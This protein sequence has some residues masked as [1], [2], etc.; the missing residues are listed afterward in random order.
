MPTGPGVQRDASVLEDLH[1]IDDEPGRLIEAIKEVMVFLQDVGVSASLSV[2]TYNEVRR[3]VCLRGAR[4]EGVIRES[5]PTA[6][7]RAGAETA[8]PV[9]VP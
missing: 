1:I 9:V 3:R 7:V 4:R 6:G 2:R 8:V 5:V